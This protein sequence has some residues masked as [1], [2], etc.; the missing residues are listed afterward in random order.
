MSG[1]CLVAGLLL[2]PLGEAV[3]LQWHHSVQKTL[4]QED[5]RRENGAVVLVEARVRGTGAGMDPPPEA[6]YREGAW[7]YRP[8]LHRFPAVELRHSP[9]VAPY[10]VCVGG[11]CHPLNQW[12]PGLA[13]DSVVR[14]S[15]C[16]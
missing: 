8:A 4:W 6:T 5:Y 2:A 7:H 15:P 10:E 11:H 16:D 1:L 13:D 14:L 3:T 12:L 9:Y